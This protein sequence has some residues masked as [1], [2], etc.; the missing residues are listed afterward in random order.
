MLTA[1]YSGKK[2]SSIDKT[3]KELVKQLKKELLSNKLMEEALNEAI[4]K[5]EELIVENEGLRNSNSLL[6]KRV[7]ILN[8]KI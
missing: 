7:G 1:S 3:H 4:E 8:R 5:N 6:E 2:Y